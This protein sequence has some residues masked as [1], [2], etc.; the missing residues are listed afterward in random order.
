[1]TTTKLAL[2]LA[3]ACVFVFEAGSGHA[4]DNSP[5]EDAMKLQLV[6][7]EFLGAEDLGHCWVIWKITRAQTCYHNK[8][9][10]QCKDRNS[11]DTRTEWDPGGACPISQEYGTGAPLRASLSRDAAL[12]TRWRPPE[13]GPPRPRTEPRSD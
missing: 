3:I 5:A 10:A 6:E 1:M 12:T 9:M 7:G 11:S 2:A 13:T 8:T 4:E